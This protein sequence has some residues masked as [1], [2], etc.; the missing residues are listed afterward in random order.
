MRMI[1]DPHTDLTDEHNAKSPYQG[2]SRF[3]AE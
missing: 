1:A 3:T 2:R